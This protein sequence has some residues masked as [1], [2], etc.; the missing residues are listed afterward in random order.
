[1]GAIKI[2]R[3]DEFN[4]QILMKVRRVLEVERPQYDKHRP[5]EMLIISSFKY[6]EKRRDVRT[7]DLNMAGIRFY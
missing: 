2:R 3:R 7:R 1:M 6:R 4:L 5:N